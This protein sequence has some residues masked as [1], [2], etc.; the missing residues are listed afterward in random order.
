[1][2]LLKMKKAPHI[3]FGV[4]LLI[5]VLSCDYEMKTLQLLSERTSEPETVIV[6]EELP[7]TLIMDSLKIKLHNISI[8]IDKSDYVLMVLSKDV[9]LKSY[10]MVLGSN[11]IDD[12]RMQGDRCTPEG[13]FLLHDM[14]YEL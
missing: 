8:Q 12:K 4:I 11:P 10:R 1:M 13:T 9:I 2:P 6:N 5:S 14:R 7:L 3:I